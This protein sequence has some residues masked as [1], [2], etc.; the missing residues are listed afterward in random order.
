MLDIVGLADEVRAMP[1]GLLTQVG[2]NGSALS[3]GQLQ[4]ACLARALLMD[5]RVLILDEFA[6]SLNTELE[7][8]IRASIDAWPRRMTIIEISH[9]PEATGHADLVATVDAGQVIEAVRKVP[10]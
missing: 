4:R 5:P 2:Q 3:G 10:R 8:H 6:A 7:D 9:R 1:E